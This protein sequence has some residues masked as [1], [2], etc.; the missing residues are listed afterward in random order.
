[1]N[2]MVRQLRIHPDCACAKMLTVPEFLLA[3]VYL[4]IATGVKSGQALQ[5]QQTKGDARCHA[6]PFNRTL[7][8]FGVVSRIHAIVACFQIIKVFGGYL[9]VNPLTKNINYANICL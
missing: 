2:L 8:E 3:S 9:I 4:L 7:Q 6:V 5:R 1:M